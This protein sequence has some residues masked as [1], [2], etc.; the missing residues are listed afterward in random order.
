MSSLKSTATL[1]EDLG[2]VPVSGSSQLPLTPVQGALHPPLAPQIVECTKYP[3][4]DI[5]LIKNNN[6]LTKQNNGQVWWVMLYNLKTGK[7]EAGGEL[8]VQG[9][10]WLHRNSG[11]S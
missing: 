3:H 9:H 1:D 5:Y 2:S 6:I 10:P 4:A 7:A 8:Q 11:L